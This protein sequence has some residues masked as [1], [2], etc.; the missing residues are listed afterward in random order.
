MLVN[1]YM[2]L[3]EHIQTTLIGGTLNF[4]EDLCNYVNDFKETISAY[5]T[6]QLQKSYL[7][8]NSDAFMKQ[9]LDVCRD[10]SVTDDDVADGI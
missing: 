1:S 5:E 8:K 7:T 4:H 2:I 9:L 6:S 10:T 3:V